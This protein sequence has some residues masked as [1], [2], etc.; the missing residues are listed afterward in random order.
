[1]R[2]GSQTLRSMREENSR[3]KDEVYRLRMEIEHLHRV[4]SALNALQYQIDAI[5]PETDVLAL[6]HNILS[7]ALQAVGSENGSLLLLD[8]EKD[9]LVFVDVI[10]T[11]GEE[12]RGYRMPADQGIAGWV[13]QQQQPALVENARK[14]ERWSP[15]VDESVGFHTASLIG[16]PL[17]DGD[18]PLGVIEAVNPLSGS[19]FRESDLDTMILVARLASLAL[20]RAEQT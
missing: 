1:M 12:L 18:R 20:A 11:S 2:A 8:Q 10:G 5:T 14:D 6:I 15:V 16:V 7:A 4:I 3:L 9:A 13:V 19:P 17:L